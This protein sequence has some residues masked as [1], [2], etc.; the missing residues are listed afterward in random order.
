MKKVTKL[1]IFSLLAF[2]L[3]SHHAFGM[4]GKEIFNTIK[5][6]GDATSGSSLAP[7]FFDGLT[8]DDINVIF[9]AY[10]YDIPETNF[11]FGG[12]TSGQFGISNKF[13]PKRTLF[14]INIIKQLTG[15]NDI[16][17]VYFS[18]PCRNYFVELSELSYSPEKEKRIGYDLEHGNYC[19]IDDILAIGTKNHKI[20]LK[21]Y[22]KKPDD[23]H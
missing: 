20:F 19:I 16:T 9:E 11:T 17:E 3:H 10:E 22:E 18:P 21:W 7:S 4:K 5:T 2:T 13:R 8:S 15:I 6:F 14:N 23:D 1:V 12:V